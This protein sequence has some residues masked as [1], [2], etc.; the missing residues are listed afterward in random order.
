M[1]N[2][3]PFKN[4]TKQYLEIIRINSLLIETDGDKGA[5]FLEAYRINHACD[6][7]TQK[8]WNENIKRHTVYALRDINKGEE[9]IITYI[10]ALKNRK[11]RREA[12]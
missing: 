4:T 7:N 12:L 9:I 8:N 6:N 11:A 10:V 2:I 5:I 1:H 3:H